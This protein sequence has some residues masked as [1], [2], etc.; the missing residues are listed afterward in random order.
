MKKIFLIMSMAAAYAVS[1][2]SAQQTLSEATDSIKNIMTQAK[3]GDAKAQNEVG[4]WY[5]T[6]KHVSQN[7]KEA[8]QWWA[9]SA[10]QGNAKAIGNLGLCYQTGNGV[11]RDSVRAISLY[12]RAIKNGNSALLEQ[13]T[14]SAD[15]GNVFDCV[16]LAECYNK[17]IGVKRDTDK[18]IEYYTKA[19][20]RNSVDAQRELALAY[21][22]GKQPA[23]AVEWFKH[24][25][26]N[27]DLPSIFY[28]GKLLSEGNGVKRDAQQGANYLLKAAEA[29]FPMGQYEIAHAYKN[30][31][32]VVKNT[33]QAISWLTKAANNGV[34]KAQFELALCYVNGDGVP[35]D[36]DQATGWFSAVLS[37][38]HGK[39]FQKLF[40]TGSE[41]SLA[42][43]PYHAYLKGLKYYN[44]KDFDNALKQ[45]KSVEKAK[46]K[47][48]KTMQGVVYANKDYA[49]HDLKKGVKTLK[50][51]AKTI[52]MAMYLLGGM[53]EAGRGVDKD[54]NQAVTYLSQA[55]A[56]GYAPALC[57]LGDMYYEGRGVEQNY[58]KAIEYYNSAKAQLTPGAAKRL[59]A[60]YENGYGGLEADKK[61]ADEILKKQNAS[62]VDILKLIPMN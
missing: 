42:G 2:L 32:G 27:N 23:K 7:Y 53:Y 57:Y 58:A 20:K 33:D 5:Y 11:E 31:N 55:A 16:L 60:C 59:A 62:T 10:Q 19:A 36:F 22:N 43:T 37:K 35:V 41:N 49:K 6:G 24:G 25:A 12:G 1:P 15:K 52:P 38:S 17:G 50:D 8:A 29:G 13:H 44:E 48:G 26:D 3:A 18:A 4:A 46:Q 56:T 34:G 61:A 9:R 45:F 54:M 28:Y 14:A 47:E 21:L 51:A 30:G 39:Q 40:E